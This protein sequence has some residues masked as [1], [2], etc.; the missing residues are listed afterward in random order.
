MKKIIFKKFNKDVFLFFITYVLS[1]ALIVW[2]IQAVNY[3]DLIYEDGHGL[4]IY[5]LYTIFLLPKVIGKLLPLIYVVSLFY[6]Y[7]KYEQQNQLI[8]YWTL[9]ISK[10]S[11]M[12]N[13]FYMSILFF[14][15]Q[16]ILTIL[17]IPASSDKGRSLFKESKLDLISSIIKEKKFVDTVKNLTIFVEDRDNNKLNKVIIKERINENSSQ[18]IIAQSGIIE[19]FKANNVLK[20]FNGKVIST[21]NDNQ[22]IVSFS[23][24][25]INLDRF[26]LNTITTR[27][28]QE[29]KST[30]LIKCVNEIIN[31]KK[32]NLIKYKEKKFLFEGCSNE[33]EQSIAEEFAERFF[34]PLYILL[35]GAISSLTIFSNKFDKNYKVSTLF[36]FLICIT[37]IIG[38]EVTLSFLNL[39]LTSIIGYILFPIICIL[40]LIYLLTF[41]K[42]ITRYEHN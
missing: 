4:K 10:F 39:E 26:N 40:F 33:I 31:L 19:N 28:T 42:M 14:L 17:I 5:F 21:I 36:Y 41:K 25:R 2:I 24:F 27:K 1:F 3:L 11:F 6:M 20:L 9:G 29:M 34:K 18:I 38:S 13:I 32:K 23:S 15:G 16:L 7:L 35:I 30:M 8:I 12:K 22:N 37:I